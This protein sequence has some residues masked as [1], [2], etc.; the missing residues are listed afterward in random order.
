MKKTLLMLITLI[1]VLSFGCKNKTEK[2]ESESAKIL[3]G[4]E[5][6]DVYLPLLK[7]KKVGLMANQT[8]IVGDKHLVDVLLEN[9]VDLKFA[10]IPEHGF[11]GTIERG[12]D[13]NNGID[14]KTG[15]PLYSLYGENHQADSL[16]SSVDIM[17]F[18]IQ[19]VG[20]RFYTY[21]VGMHNVMQLCADNNRP[22]MIL[23]RPNPNGEQVDGPVRKD[24]R[25]KSDI[26][27]HKVAMVHGL[28][29]GE[30]AQMIN[31]E[32]WLDNGKQCELTVVPLKNYTHKSRY[33]LPVIPSPSLPNHLSVRLFP[34]LCL[35][36]GT[37]C[38]I[39]RGT[40]FPFQV[41][42][43]PDP[44]F[45]DFTFTPGSKSGMSVHVEQQGNLCYGA[46]LRSL[47]PDSIRFSL[48]YILE[49]YSKAPDK[50]FARPDFFDL[51]AGT[52]KL[53]E[54]ISEGWTEEQIRD[55]W[56]EELAEYKNMR[57]KYLLYEDFE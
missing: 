8:T 25:F 31:G 27:F 18:D 40:D 11:R 15:L 5:Q 43:Y 24:D 13:V 17:I 1:G 32:G 39:G 16:V 37:D 7:G 41:I 10:F 9:E 28:T 55:S 46:D 2:S 29:I 30:L 22:V 20:A 34:S 57:K 56:K 3:T 49:Y 54:Q 44:S 53:R 21:V 35:F 51:L 36:E 45:G 52:D 12:E 48:K 6:L 47:D 4:A 50:F 19:D 33:E 14:E 38:S 23:D 42:G 26:S